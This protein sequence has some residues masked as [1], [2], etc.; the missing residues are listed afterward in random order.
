M[1]TF[2]STRLHTRATLEK[3]S[4]LIISSNNWTAVMAPAT[5]PTAA[6]LSS[7][8]SVV[9]PFSAPVTIP[10]VAPP[11]QERTWRETRQFS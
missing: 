11:E 3:D 9:C 6:P 5:E 7:P 10:T 8:V 4:P 2:P 1:N